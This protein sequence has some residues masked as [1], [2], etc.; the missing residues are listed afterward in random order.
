MQ[1][2]FFTNSAVP[3]FRSVFAQHKKQLLLVTERMLCTGNGV[4]EISE[5]WFKHADA[6][7]LEP[8]LA[9]A[10]AIKSS[11]AL[12]LWSAL[13]CFTREYMIS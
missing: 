11:I 5:C 2:D 3:G 1:D 9:Q 4:Y 10:Q 12:E 8:I 13:A 7:I 6:D